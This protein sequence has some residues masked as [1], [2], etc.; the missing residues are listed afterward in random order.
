MKNPIGLVCVATLCM[1]ATPT[2]SDDKDEA[3]LAALA[4]LGIA[5]LA[6][7]DDHYR[8]G[9]EPKSAQQTARFERGYRDGLHNEHYDTAHSS[10]MYAQGYD[11]GQK[12]R[13]NRLAHKRQA[14]NE[15]QLPNGIAA[16]SCVGQ[17]SADWGRNPRDIH[18]VAR[19][20][21]SFS[22]AG[23]QEILIEL[24]AGHK[25]GICRVNQNG[26]VF[27]VRNGRL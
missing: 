8:A 11:A 18:V 12:E 17:A 27:E 25:H 22:Q 20:K 15:N 21:G 24:A 1:I 5:A 16:R 9:N 19:R 10:A 26:T 14:N 3:A 23:G 6:H 13:S 2:W 7:H 4:L